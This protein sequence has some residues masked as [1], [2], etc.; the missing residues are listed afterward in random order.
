MVS[1]RG[2]HRAAPLPRIIIW[3]LGG[4]FQEEAITIPAFNPVAAIKA[5][6]DH[7]VAHGAVAAIAFYLISVCGNFND[8]RG[9]GCILGA[10]EF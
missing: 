3:Y 10:H 7:G 2:P 4:F 1:I 5:V 8:F 9:L 6:P